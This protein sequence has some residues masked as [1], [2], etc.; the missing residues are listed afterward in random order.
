MNE[1]ESTGD[2]KMAPTCIV[3]LNIFRQVMYVPIVVKYVIATDKS[4]LENFKTLIQERTFVLLGS[5]LIL[6]LYLH[7]FYIYIYM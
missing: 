3:F 6:L 7:T 5:L 1:N 2:L 4:S